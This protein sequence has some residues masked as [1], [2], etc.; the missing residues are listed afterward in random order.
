M[1]TFLIL[2]LLFIST[3]SFAQNKFAI[4]YFSSNY[5][6]IVYI[7]NSND[8]E[9]P[10]WIA[11]YDNNTNE[12]LIKIESERIYLD[13]NDKKAIKID[14]ILPYKE[15]SFIIY[16]D[17]NFDGAEDFAIED[18][19]HSCNGLP[20]YK[21]FLAEN[22]RF[23]FSEKFT[24]LAQNYCGMFAVVREK[25]M[26]RTELKSGCCYHVYSEFIIDDG[27]PKLT[28][29]ITED[30]TQGDEYVY[31]TTEKLVNEEWSKTVRKEK[32][33]EYYK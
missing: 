4:E 17:F 1:K 25:K 22:N 29:K 9:N 23:V 30:A 18:G 15:Q 27:A 24:E 26:L 28:S 10:G 5:Y 7:T 33:E 12:E 32:I 6:C 3:I 16:N 11:V 21:I 2:V 19:H 13:S 8:E 14:N 20:S 31:I